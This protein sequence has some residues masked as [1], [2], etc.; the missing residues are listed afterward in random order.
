VGLLRGPDDFRLFRPYICDDVTAFGALT[1]KPTL[2]RQTGTHALPRT[3]TLTTGT[4]V[5][6]C[7]APWTDV[8][9]KKRVRQHL[10]ENWASWGAR[11]SLIVLDHGGLT[12]TKGVCEV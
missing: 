3:Y 11:R 4:L 9:M 5:R 8:L 6:Q 12:P 10:H 2:V 1:Y 7:I